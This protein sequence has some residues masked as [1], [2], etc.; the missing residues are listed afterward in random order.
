MQIAVVLRRRYQF[1]AATH[2]KN[3]VPCISSYTDIALHKL[4]LFTYVFLN[5]PPLGVAKDK[6]SSQI[7]S[8]K[9]LYSFKPDD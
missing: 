7:E 8:E 9:N 3:K 5:V 4:A 6:Q 2:C 1:F